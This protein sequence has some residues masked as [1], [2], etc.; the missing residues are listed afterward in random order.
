VRHASPAEPRRA[1]EIDPPIGLLD[2]HHEMMRRI[3]DIE[4]RIRARTDQ[5][6]RIPW[7]YSRRR[8]EKVRHPVIIGRDAVLLENDARIAPMAHDRCTPDSCRLVATPKSAESGPNRK[9][10]QSDFKRLHNV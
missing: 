9:S 7:P 1:I 3:A 4:G 8:F 6:V 5:E 10:S 2:G